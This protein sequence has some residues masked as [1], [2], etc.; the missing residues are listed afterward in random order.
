MNVSRLCWQIQRD[1]GVLHD[2]NADSM[3]EKQIANSRVR[4]PQVNHDNVAHRF[5]CLFMSHAGGNGGGASNDFVRRDMHILAAFTCDNTD[6]LREG[7]RRWWV[8]PTRRLALA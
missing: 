1:I 4:D 3:S 2:R 6:I 7:H 8:Q 5:V